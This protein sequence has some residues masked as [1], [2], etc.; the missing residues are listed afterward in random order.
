M[1][2]ETP[3]R[4]IWR[5]RFAIGSLILF[6]SFIGLLMGNLFQKGNWMYW[7]WMAP[8]FAL[9]CLL[10]SFYLRKKNHSRSLVTIWHEL[11][12]WIGV[13]ATIYLVSLFTR[14]GLMGHIQESLVVMSIL[15]LAI[16]LNGLYG[17]WS[18]ILIGIILAIFTAGAAFAEAYL[19]TIMLPILIGG[20]ALHALISHLLHHK[21]FPTQE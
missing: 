3:K 2:N 6:L 14:T 21:N 20:I 4:F 17:E 1:E 19:Y 12:H 9:L 16:F 7:R 13:L 10:L 11:A 15:A 18:L 5:M 8:I